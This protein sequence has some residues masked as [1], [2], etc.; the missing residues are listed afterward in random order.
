MI[1]KKPSADAWESMEWIWHVLSYAFL[2][3]TVVLALGSDSSQPARAVFLGASIG[4]ALWYVPFIITPPSRWHDHPLRTL[5]YFGL[6]WGLWAA[7][8]LEY[9]GALLLMGLFFPALFVR[10]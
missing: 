8:M 9:Q 5:L 1:A 7:L 4:L 3:M 10:F 6:G 2:V